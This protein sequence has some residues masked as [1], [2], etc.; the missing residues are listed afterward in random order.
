MD[1]S[2]PVFAAQVRAARALLEWSQSE[3]AERSRVSRPVIARLEKHATDARSSTVRAIKAAFEAAGVFL[4]SESD[5]S[6]GLI[7][8]PRTDG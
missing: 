2:D 7:K 6:Y 5:G 1:P 4:V 3:L 8:R